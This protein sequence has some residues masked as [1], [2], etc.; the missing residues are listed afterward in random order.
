MLDILK[1]LFLRSYDLNDAT[2]WSGESAGPEPETPRPPRRPETR[3]G[4]RDGAE[5]DSVSVVSGK[6][7]TRTLRKSSSRR[8]REAIA[9]ESVAVSSRLKA[10]VDLILGIWEQ[11]H[12]VGY[13]V[14]G[15]SRFSKI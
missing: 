12:N 9:A 6:A 5:D 11:T 14:P 10:E 13:D 4:D 7:G 8:A 15:E 1:K 2:S 3:L